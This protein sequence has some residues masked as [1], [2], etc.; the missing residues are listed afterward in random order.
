MHTQNRV[1]SCILFINYCFIFHVNNC[2]PPLAPPCA[3]RFAWAHGYIEKSLLNLSLGR[4]PGLCPQCPLLAYSAWV[5]PLGS[6]V[7]LCP[8]N[9]LLSFSLGMQKPRRLPAPHSFR[10]GSQ[11]AWL[12]YSDSFEVPY[13]PHKEL[14]QL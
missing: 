11:L 7:T 10:G 3:N 6:V 12:P 9:T 14:L 13:T 2:K 4:P 8:Q 5:T 1:Q